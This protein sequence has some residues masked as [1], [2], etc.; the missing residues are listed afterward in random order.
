M[1]HFVHI[2]QAG[3]QLFAHLYMLFSCQQDVCCLRHG[4]LAREE[5]GMR[6]ATINLQRKVTKI[7]EGGES[8]DSMIAEGSLRRDAG[9][10]AC[11]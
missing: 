2:G 1:C 3:V 4:T 11:G 10:T 7:E 6:N 8:I 9:L 5:D